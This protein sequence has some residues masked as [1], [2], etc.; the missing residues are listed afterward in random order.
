MHRV[1]P[2]VLTD[3]LVAHCRYNG[4][5]YPYMEKHR[6]C[7]DA[8]LDIVGADG[9]RWG[10]FDVKLVL[11]REYPEGI[12]AVFEQRSRIK[13]EADWHINE[14]GSC[15][16][17]PWVGE[18]KKYSG[19]AVLMDWLDRSVVPFFANHLYKERHGH[20][21]SGEYSHG[22]QGILEYYQEIWPG[23]LEDIIKKLRQVTGAEHPNAK[24][25]CFCGSGE[26]YAACHAGQLEYDGISRASYKQDLAYL[27]LFAESLRFSE[28]TRTECVAGQP[29]IR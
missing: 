21:R 13:A 9:A 24:E 28:A 12:P 10:A 14:D 8:T 15:C 19:R 29:G 11:P 16:L 3:V 6:W 20:Y 1:D 23:E 26:R 25:K 17:G 7:V 2:V 27:K 22:F 4:L 18:M 5:R